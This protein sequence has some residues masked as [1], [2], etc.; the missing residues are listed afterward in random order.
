[1]TSCYVETLRKVAELWLL[2][3][4]EKKSNMSPSQ[5]AEMLASVN[6]KFTTAIASFAESC[7]S[8]FT[9]AEEDAN[10]LMTSLFLQVT[11]VNSVTEKC[12]KQLLP[13][14]TLFLLP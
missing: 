2:E 3:G 4:N 7:S 8:V 9:E 13:V 11:E 5:K 10:E 6:M 1:M 14:L 12:T